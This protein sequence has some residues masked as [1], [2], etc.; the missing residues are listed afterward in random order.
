MVDGRKITASPC[1]VSGSMDGNGATNTITGTLR[2]VT[3][4]AGNSGKLQLKNV[5]FDGSD[6]V[7]SVN[8]GAFT[9]IAENDILTFTTGQSIQFRGTGLTTGGMT[10]QCDVYDFDTNALLASFSHVTM[11]RT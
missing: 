2:T 4:P 11:T 3:V 1:T 9:T 7:V 8:G 10:A 6:F 5:A